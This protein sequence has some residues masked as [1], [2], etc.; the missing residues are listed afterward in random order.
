MS[1][2]RSR[3]LTIFNGLDPPTGVVAWKRLELR[4]IHKSGRK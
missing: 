4:A 3:D 1:D 2:L